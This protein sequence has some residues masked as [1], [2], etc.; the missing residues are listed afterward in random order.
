MVPVRFAP[1]QARFEGH[2]RES[3][4]EIRKVDVVA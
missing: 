1:R 2:A 4:E 3:H